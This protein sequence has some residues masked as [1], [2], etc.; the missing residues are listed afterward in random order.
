MGKIKKQLPENDDIAELLELSI[1]YPRN[2]KQLVKL[3][4]N[5]DKLNSFGKT[6]L[7]TAAQYGYLESVKILLDAGVDINHQT[8]ATNCFSDFEIECIDNGKRSAL[9]YA[10]Q[11]NQFKVAEYLLD[12]GADI[13]LTD[14]Q[15]MTALDYLMKK[16][17]KFSAHRTGTIYGGEANWKIPEDKEKLPAQQYDKLYKRLFFNQQPQIADVLIGKWESRDKNETAVFEKNMKPNEPLLIVK[18]TDGIFAVCD[19]QEDSRNVFN[20]I[21][22][23]DKGDKNKFDVFFA[24]SHYYKDKVI[25]YYSLEP[26][27]L[28]RCAQDDACEPEILATLEREAEHDKK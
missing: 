23:P 18:N 10:L 16:A 24:I 26:N 5:V 2:L 17:P 8:D 13:T 27:E 7:Q 25:I 12:K 3:T 11:E 15:E 6:P 19:A 21:F 4:K 22:E 9:M 20:C 14:S 1:A 28:N